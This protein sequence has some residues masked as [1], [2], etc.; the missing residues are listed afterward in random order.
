MTNYQPEITASFQINHNYRGE[1]AITL[2]YGTAAHP[3]ATKVFSNVVLGGNRPFCSNNIVVDITEFK[4]SMTGLYNQPFF[5]SV[6]DS[7]TTTIGTV[8]YFAVESTVSADTPKQTINSV[9]VTFA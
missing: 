6:R 4:S 9:T 5:L 3:V 1:C 8:N 7:G 2:G